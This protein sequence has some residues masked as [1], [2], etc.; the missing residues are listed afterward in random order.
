MRDG[1]ADEPRRRAANGRRLGRPT[2]ADDERETR[3]TDDRH[4]TSRRYDAGRVGFA[5][6]F[7]PAAS[8]EKRG[9][10]PPARYS[11]AG[12]RTRPVSRERPVPTRQTSHTYAPDGRRAPCDR[13]ARVWTAKSPPDWPRPT[14]VR[15]VVARRARGYAR[16][17]VFSARRSSVAPLSTS[18]APCTSVPPPPR[19]RPVL[20][21]FPAATRRRVPFASPDF[22]RVAA[23]TR[24]P[25]P[26]ARAAA[27]TDNA[28]AGPTGSLQMSAPTSSASTCSFSSSVSSRSIASARVLRCAV[29]GERAEYSHG[30]ADFVARRTKKRIRGRTP[31][32]DA[33]RIVSR[34]T[35]ASPPRSAVFTRATR[36]PEP[37]SRSTAFA[38]AIGRCAVSTAEHTV[39]AGPR[40]RRVH[41]RM[42]FATCAASSVQAT[43]PSDHRSSAVSDADAPEA[44]VDRPRPPSALRPSPSPSIV[45]SRSIVFSTLLLL[46]AFPLDRV[47]VRGESIDASRQSIVRRVRAP[48]GRRTRASP[49]RRRRRGPRLRVSLSSGRRRRPSQFLQRERR[50]RARGAH[51]RVARGFARRRGGVQRA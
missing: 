2:R 12:S 6:A 24:S 7:D 35:R 37:R 28:P 29:A 18:A 34:N 21:A 47:R 9:E 17:R 22:R 31:A 16:G 46:L 51:E 1:D 10:A 38:R 19:L 3:R 33:G 8:K 30:A 27:R 32:L 15:R 43:H 49:P 5:V 23:R 14:A 45:F 26:R 50:G 36:A 20:R 44:S 42:T 25:R 39:A 41:P 4:D 11:R 13:F 40:A 48:G